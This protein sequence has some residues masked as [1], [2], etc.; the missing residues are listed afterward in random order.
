MTVYDQEVSRKI[1]DLVNE[2]RVKEGHAAMIWDDMVPRS[3]SIAVAGYHM[4]KSI[5][6]LDMVHRIIW[7]YILVVRM[8][9]VEIYFLQTQMISHSRFSIFGCLH[10]GIRQTKWM[11]IIRMVL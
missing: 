11:I 8:V 7:H 3:R 5:T 9:V 6:D 10:Q 1:F 4:M 2:E